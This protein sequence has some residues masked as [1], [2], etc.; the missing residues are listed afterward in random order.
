MP[1]TLVTWNLQGSAGVDV[2]QVAASLRDAGASVVFL[3]EVGRRDAT[4]ISQALGAASVTWGFKH[5]PV[6]RRPEGMAVLGVVA[7]VPATTMA[8]TYRWRWWSWRRRIVQHAR[9]VVDGMAISAVNAHL[10][11]HGAEDLRRR[12]VEQLLQCAGDISRSIVAGDLN[13]GPRGPVVGRLANAGLRDAR[14][15]ATSR[16][17]GDNTNWSG[18]RSGPPDQCL[19]YVFHGE[20]LQAVSLAVPSVPDAAGWTRWAALSDHLPVTVVL[21]AQ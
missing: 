12:E 14:E 19:D 7:R 11:P 3:Q 1:M 18:T 4:A 6:I 5:W 20:A 2:E 16:S 17:G 21:T 9:L 10:S 15:S 8:L 13:D